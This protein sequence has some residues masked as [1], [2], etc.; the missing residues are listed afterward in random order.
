MG[1]RLQGGGGVLGDAKALVLVQAGEPGRQEA[2]SSV[3]RKQTQAD[4]DE[5]DGQG[6]KPE[7]RCQG[8][9]QTGRPGGGELL[10]A[11]TS[12]L[13]TGRNSAGSDGSPIDRPT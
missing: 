5:H 3:R 9:S 8:C 12:G 4:E 7:Q 10:Q 2:E 1:Q 11:L 13:P 6:R